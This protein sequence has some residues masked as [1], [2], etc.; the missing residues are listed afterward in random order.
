MKRPYSMSNRAAAAA[1]AAATS[2]VA[3]NKSIFNSDTL[4]SHIG[5][6]F[7]SP[8]SYPSYDE[9]KGKRVAET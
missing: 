8:P 3:L 9:N 7:F 5:R 6:S 1:A 4:S 2:A